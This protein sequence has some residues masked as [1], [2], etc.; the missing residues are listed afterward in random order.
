MSCVA[1]PG[2]GV[3]WAVADG[4][5]LGTQSIMPSTILIP[6]LWHMRA[7]GLAVGDVI[8]PGRLGH[9]LPIEAAGSALFFRE[10]LVELF[11]SKGLDRPCLG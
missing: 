2:R 10:Y 6:R 5:V 9:D 11:A 3:E 8:Q 1:V 4:R 7:P